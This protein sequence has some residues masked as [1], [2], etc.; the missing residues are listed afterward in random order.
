MKNALDPVFLS[1][2][3]TPIPQLNN[4]NNT[5]S[6]QPTSNKNSLKITLKIESNDTNAST[7]D[8]GFDND[9]YFPRSLCPLS[10]TSSS[11]ST[12]LTHQ[13]NNISTVD[14]QCKVPSNNSF[15]MVGNNDD[16]I[17]DMTTTTPVIGSDFDM[18]TN[19]FDKEEDKKPFTFND[20]NH[21]HSLNNETDLNLDSENLNNLID[22]K[23]EYFGDKSI[24]DDEEFVSHVK[25]AN[26]LS[27]A[28]VDV[29]NN[30]HAINYKIANHK[31]V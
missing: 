26:M 19:F 6:I 5:I 25:A 17:S 3:F 23:D 8:Q 1:S 11:I 14:E 10:N 9:N 16:L 24:D 20:F 13:Q 2:N 30:L 21:Y 12:F 28:L 15:G 7:L 27:S 22:L 18:S 29:M 4:P 31:Y